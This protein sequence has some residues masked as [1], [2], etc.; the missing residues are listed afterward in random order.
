MELK[1]SKKIEVKFFEVSYSDGDVRI[2]YVA[3]NK[4]QVKMAEDD[5]CGLEGL[6]Y[7]KELTAPEIN[8]KVKIGKKISSL[9]EQAILVIELEGFSLP[10]TIASSG[11]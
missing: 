11:I 4:K 10:R 1:I 9:K 5:A 3:K 2:V 8:K 6:D 7:I